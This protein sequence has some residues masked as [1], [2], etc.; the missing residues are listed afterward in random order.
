MPKNYSSRPFY[1]N[2]FKEMAQKIKSLQPEDGLWRTSLLSPESYSHGEVSASGLYTFALACGINS[3]LL[4]RSEYQPAVLKAWNAILACQQE[5]GK[6]GWVQNIGANPG[7]ATADSW[8]N[9][10][11]GAFLLAGSEVLKL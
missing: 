4:K 6:V 2:L 7:P 3:G 1:E 9:Y 10:G 8:Q 5:K 11:T